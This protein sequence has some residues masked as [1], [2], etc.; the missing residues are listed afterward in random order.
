[1]CSYPESEWDDQ[2]QG[3]MLALALWDST[4]C[5]ACGGDLRETTEHEDWVAAVPVQCHRC[6]AMTAK[7][8]AYAKDYP[9]LMH[10]FRWTA[11]RR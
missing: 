9:T 10:T 2:Q 5:E 7:Q 6:A 1:M 8:D 4:R 3:W 11:T